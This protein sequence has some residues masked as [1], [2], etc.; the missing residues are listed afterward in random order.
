[1]TMIRFCLL[2]RSEVVWVFS[3]PGAAP[4]EKNTWVSLTLSLSL[5]LSPFPCL[6]GTSVPPSS[7]CLARLLAC[8]TTVPQV[9]RIRS[10][11]P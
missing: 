3:S 4:Q 6:P 8:E 2:D 7:L 9:L 1:M 11:V 10:K 5:S